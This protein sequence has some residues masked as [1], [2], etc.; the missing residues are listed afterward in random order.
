[1]A[2]VSNIVISSVE[3]YSFKESTVINIVITC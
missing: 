3:M 2:R 1:M